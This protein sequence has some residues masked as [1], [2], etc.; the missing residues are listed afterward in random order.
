VT[1]WIYVESYWCIVAWLM[2]ALVGLVIGYLIGRYES[3]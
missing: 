2:G 1:W 3:K